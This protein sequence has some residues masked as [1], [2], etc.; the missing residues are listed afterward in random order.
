MKKYCFVITAVLSLL[1]FTRLSAQVTTADNDD[2]VVITQSGKVKGSM[3]NGV[4]V[5]KSIPYAAPPVGEHHFAI[6]APHLPWQGTRDATKQGPSAPFPKQAAGD[7]DDTPT[8]GKGWIKGD[9]FLTTNVWT[10][11]TGD[12]H[13]PVMVYIHGGAFVIGTSDVPLF[14]G[15]AFAKKGVVMVSLNYR[16]GIEGFLKIPGVPS[17]LG[18]RDQ[19]AALKWVQDNIA[20]FG[21]DKDN[22]TV[23]GE[24]AGAISVG[25]LIASPAA[26]GLFKR[27]IMQSGSGQAALS[28]EQA[29]RIATQYAKTLKIKNSRE[30]YLN[31]TPEELLAAQPKVTPKMLQLKTKTHEDPTGG[32]AIFFPVIDGDIIPDMPLTTVR[33][34]QASEYDLLLG[35]N[36]DEMN[37]FLIPTGVLKKIKLPLV[38]N[39]AVRKV[40]PAPA[41]LIALFRKE[42]PKKNLGEIFSAI[43]T[44]YQAQVPAIRF[45]NAQAASGGKTFMYE[46]AWPSSVKNGIYGSYH[47]LE[48]PFVFNNLQSKGERGMLGPEGG[49]QQLA[50]KMQDAWV[51]FATNGSPGWDAYTTTERKTMLIDTNWELQTNPHAKVLAAWDGV[52]DK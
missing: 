10:P 23:F 5:F 42:Y 45:A 4:M 30:S 2:L 43:L 18:I 14:D 37:L 33:N 47:G 28:G 36:T 34:K 27:C 12:K 20:A 50:D 51:K 8:L 41:P 1:N 25:V 3:L 17:N 40:H 38:L 19:I 15:T 46:F 7:I 13:L 39:I 26:L 32:V 22:V 6:P 49:P 52:R 35:Y 29:D 44:S 21:G 48:M 9:D 31:F 11:A 24:S 16:M